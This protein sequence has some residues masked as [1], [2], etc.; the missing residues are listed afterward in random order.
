M[1]RLV[2]TLYNDS[3]WHLVVLSPDEL[4]TPGNASML[5][6]ETP[7]SVHP[8]HDN[9]LPSRAAWPNG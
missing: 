4:R 9:P 1:H 2:Q 6:R 8:K 5:G 7:L 3:P